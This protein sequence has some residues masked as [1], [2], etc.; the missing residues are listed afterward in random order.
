MLR[1]QDS[2]LKEIMLL[3]V[4]I[5]IVL[6]MSLDMASKADIATRIW[7]YQEAAIRVVMDIMTGAAFDLIIVHTVQLNLIPNGR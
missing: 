4:S 3:L 1:L 7:F 6:A 2:H 5:S